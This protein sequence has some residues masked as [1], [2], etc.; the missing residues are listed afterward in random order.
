[1]KKFGLVLLLPLLVIAA[2]RAQ[3]ALLADHPEVASSIRLLEAWIE[4]QMAYRG[5]PGMSIGIV[6]NQDLIW[7]RG[8]GYSDVDKKIGATPTTIYRMASVTKLFTATAISSFAT[9]VSCAWTIPL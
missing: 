3:N 7:S 1:M 4:S 5:L 8:F 2:A 6:Y 9:K